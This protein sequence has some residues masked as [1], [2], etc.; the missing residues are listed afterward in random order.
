MSP[1]I[2]GNMRYA[3]DALSWLNGLGMG[4]Q[5]LRPLKEQSSP[6]ELDEHFAAETGTNSASQMLMCVLHFI[7]SI[8]VTRVVEQRRTKVAGILLCWNWQA[9]GFRPCL[10]V[11][12]G[13][14]TIR[15]QRSWKGA[16]DRHKAR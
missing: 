2:C 10:F 8:A 14:P 7:E 15:N 4:A 5:H 11:V 3:S 16:S 1:I 12:C 9:C 6:H 13:A